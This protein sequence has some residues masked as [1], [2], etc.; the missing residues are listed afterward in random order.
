METWG[1]KDSQ[2]QNLRMRTKLPQWVSQR[3]V[4]R[5]QRGQTAR[6]WSLASCGNGSQ[7]EN[8]N[9]ECCELPWVW[10]LSRSLLTV[11]WTLSCEPHGHY[12]LEHSSC[13][14]FSKSGLLV[15]LHSINKRQGWTLRLGFRHSFWYPSPELCVTLPQLHVVSE[16]ERLIKGNSIHAAM[17][18]SRWCDCFGGRGGGVEVGDHVPVSN[19][20]LMGL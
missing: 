12:H 20:S 17:G 3:S 9:W 19:P 7:W 11:L 6:R 1:S 8:L 18:K 4:Y 15:F 5:G 13:E 14:K 10:N 2:L 16:D